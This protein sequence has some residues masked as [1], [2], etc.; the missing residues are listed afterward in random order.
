[1]ELLERATTASVF[2]LHLAACQ[3]ELPARH[4][5]P[6][7]VWGKLIVY[8]S[9]TV[10]MPDTTA[11]LERGLRDVPH[12]GEVIRAGHPICTVLA[13]GSTR[14]ACEDALRSAAT[15]VETACSPVDQSIPADDLEDDE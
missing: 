14:T 2:G 15:W 4:A 8:A 7:G 11:W 13:S 3:G 9:R 6:A 12:P 10:A 5:D 1:M